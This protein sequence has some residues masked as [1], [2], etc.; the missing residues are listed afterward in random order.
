[1][2]VIKQRLARPRF[3]PTDRVDQPNHIVISTT[4]SLGYI[5]WTAQREL[6]QNFMNFTKKNVIRSTKWE[7]GYKIVIR[8]FRR[9]LAIARNQI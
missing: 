9:L 3:P 4:P 2:L 5:D 7:W 6:K 8:S 1:M